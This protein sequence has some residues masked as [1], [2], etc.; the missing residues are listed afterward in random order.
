MGNLTSTPNENMNIKEPM[1]KQENSVN[2]EEIFNKIWE[3][4]NNLLVEYNNE[5]LKEDFCNKIAIIYEKKLSKFNIKLLKSLYN[6]INSENIDNE[7][8]MTLQYVPKND[9]EFF[10]DTFK[11]NLNEKFWKEKIELDPQFLVNNMKDIDIN[12]IKSSIKYLPYYI[13]PV[14]VNNLLQSI[15]KI[16]DELKP[17]NGVSNITSNVASNVTKNEVKTGG[18]NNRVKIVNNSEYNRGQNFLNKMGLENNEQH[19]KSKLSPKKNKKYNNIN[20][21]LENSQNSNNKNNNEENNNEENNN[22]ENINE[23]NINL[24]NLEKNNRRNQSSNRINEKQKSLNST[25]SQQTP[26]ISTNSQQKPHIS[27]NSQQK[28]SNSTNSYQKPPNSINRQPISSNIINSEKSNPSQIIVQEYIPKNSSLQQLNEV[29]NTIIAKNINIPLEKNIDDKMINDHIKYYVPK[30]YQK[31]TPF[32]TNMEKCKLSKKDLCTAITENFIV[33]NN[34]I[35]AILTTVPFKNSE[36]LY[37][38]GICFQ[39]FM[40]LNNCNVCVPYDYRELKNKD[41]KSILTKILEKADNLDESRCRENQGYFLK[42]SDNEKKILA[43]KIS[44]ISEK[45][46]NNYPKIKYNYYFIEFTK[47]LQNNYLQNLNSLITILEKLKESPVINNATLNLI[48][49][50]TKKIIDH[51]YNTCHYYYVYAI[52]SLISSDITEDIIK[53]DDLANIVSIALEK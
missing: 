27:T 35:A 11:D 28:S 32:C 41:I 21:Y 53:K 22:E 31:P 49:D 6:N 26:P 3:I 36:G 4:S 40:N 17:S 48:S 5:F 51:M 16:N 1:Q 12:N 37:E 18:F 23:E 24:N 52:I 29:T 13:N 25:N 20:Q 50:E 34:I 39:K 2:E 10:T 45:D 33:R 8:L 15:N 42:L 44:N 9:D 43:S 7:M 30:N 46:I 38:G 47:K 14:H 19:N